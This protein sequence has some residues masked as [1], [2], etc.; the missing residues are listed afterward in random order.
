V[1]GSYPAGYRIQLSLDGK[2]WG[3]PVAEG[4]G[5]AATTIATFRPAR[6]KFV[7]VTQTD[8]PDPALPWS[9]LNFRVYVA[10]K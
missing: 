6:A 3:A 7:R 4:K 2:T 5:A 9:V 10:G 8:A 1:F